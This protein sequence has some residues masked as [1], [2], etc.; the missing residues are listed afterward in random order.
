MC[1]RRQRF[2]TD[3]RDCSPGLGRDFFDTVQFLFRLY[4][5]R[6]A[7]TGFNLLN[8]NGKSAEQSIDHLHFHFFPRLEED[9]LSTWPA[10]PS[11]EYDLGKLFKLLRGS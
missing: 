11:I 5:E 1:R 10:L 2:E 8:A 9:G 6:I 3:L 7:A 4:R